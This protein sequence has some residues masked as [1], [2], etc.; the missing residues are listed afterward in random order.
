V[1][2]GDRVL[3]QR[4]PAHVDEQLDP[5]R[6]LAESDRRPLALR[7]LGLERDRAER[8]QRQR[9]DHG[10]RRVSLAAA[11]VDLDV[12][13]AASDAVDGDSEPVLERRGAGD[14]V[15]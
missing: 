15:E 10:A 2:G 4:L 7:Q 8:V 13:L 6:S 3:E 11:Q 14:R 12:A 5:A 9:E 1:T